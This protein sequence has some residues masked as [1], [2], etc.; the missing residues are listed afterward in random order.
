MRHRNYTKK[1][2]YPVIAEQADRLKSQD[3]LANYSKSTR[4]SQIA[5]DNKISI[6]SSNVIN[7]IMNYSSC[8]QKVFKNEV[9]VQV[10]QS[11]FTNTTFLL[12]TGASVSLIKISS[13]KDEVQVYINRTIQIKGITSDI[14]TTLGVVFLNISISNAQNIRH[15]FH[16]VP[17]NFPIS[18]HGILG[19]DF[20]T[21]TNASVNYNTQ[22]FSFQIEGKEVHLK[23]VYSDQRVKIP[24]RTE[25]VLKLGPFHE[26]EEIICFPGEIADQVYTPGIVTKPVDGTVEIPVLNASENEIEVDSSARIKYDHLAKYILY[27]LDEIQNNNN[28]AKRLRTL[29]SL[30]DL[31]DLN[32]EERQSILDIC[33]EFN[34]LFY[35]EGDSLTTTTAIKHEIKTL[36]EKPPVNTRPYR[37]PEVHKAEIKSQVDKMLQEGVV[38]PSSSPWNSPLLVVPKKPDS[39]GQRKWRVVVDF[40]KLNEITVADAFPLPNIEDILGQLGDSKYFSTLDLA[41]GFHQIGVREEDK[42]KT[43]FSTPHGHFEFNRMP[44]G[45]RNAPP[46]FQRLMN[47]VLTGLQGIRCL[48]YLDDIVIYAKNLSDHQLKLKEVLNSLRKYNLKLQPTKCKFLRKEVVYLGHLISGNGIQPDP[49]KTNVIQS[50]TPPKDRKQVKSFLGLVGYYRK[51]IPNFAKLAHPLNRLL[52]QD[53][54][55]EWDAICDESFE[56]LKEAIVKP[57]ILQYPNFCRRF[58]IT[59]DASN[60]A[61]GAVL[62]QKDDPNGL[63]LPIAFA[64]RVLNKAEK[65]YSTIE[66]EAL[67]VVW[68]VTH[69]RPYVYGQKFTVVTDHKPLVW[70]F[71]LK[72]PSSRIMRWRIKLEEYDFDV[73]HK[74][75]RL[76]SNA[77]ALSRLD[78]ANVNVITRSKAQQT[79]DTEPI[80]SKEKDTTP[81]I[82]LSDQSDIQRALYEFHNS[83]VGGHLGVAKTFK[84]IRSKYKW[85]NM[86]GDIKRYIAKCDTCQKNKVGRRTKLPMRITTTAKRPFERIA[87]DIVG[88][89]PLSEHNNRYI[90]TFQDDLSKFLIAIPIPNQEAHTVAEYYVRKI[91][92]LFGTPT[93]LLTDQGSNFLGELFERVCKLLK[94][95]KVRSSPYHPQTNGSLER[96]HRDLGNYLRSFASR[97]PTNW[98]T[99]LDY[100]ILCHNTTPH[101]ATQY[102]PYEVLFG[103]K[104]ELPSSLS[105][106]PEP[107][108]NYDD[109]VQELKARLQVTYQ[110]VRENQLNAKEKSKT[111]YDANVKSLELNVGDLVLLENKARKSKKLTS[112]FE[113]P[114]EVVE[115]NS[116]VNSTIK[117]GRKTKLVHNNLLK[118]Y[119]T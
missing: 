27:N 63:D 92:C 15:A 1:H 45:L 54:G 61:I 78:T 104:P 115:L 40:R 65:N 109:Y 67:A 46:T 53:V 21:Q 111:Y 38:R 72:D 64:S 51:F 10:A 70:I 83:P 106:A 117:I 89:L 59:T 100:S 17:S 99:W 41:N 48:V 24:P 118:R 18:S 112:I 11:A 12:D 44:F 105:R 88:P 90:L 108:Y 56:L 6:G 98:D 25:K 71:N 113:G 97:D 26:T 22:T 75:G 107:V 14:I 31:K 74:S 81:V 4:N 119:I 8:K 23:F 52:K 69:F 110:H 7:K 2:S 32:T 82:E 85:K 33:R 91:I 42:P 58:F 94:I 73:I 114:Y 49:N 76:N 39:N 93:S 36:P 43:A 96:C 60:V 116:P 47:K 79:K 68:A 101:S 19:Q 86:F 84:R 57:P 29:E 20:F 87:L 34:D 35:L 62:S 9:S 50:I 77:D 28:I 102:T 55:F 103:M 37:M 3:N 5:V 95:K 66:K 13:L 16:V 80:F 30:L